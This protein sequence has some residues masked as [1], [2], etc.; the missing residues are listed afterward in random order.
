MPESDALLTFAELGVGLAG[1]AGIFFAL[2]RRD[3]VHFVALL[4]S[5]LLSGARLP[6]S[7]GMESA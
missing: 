2:T 3:G 5:R 6:E 7:A 4:S 1:F